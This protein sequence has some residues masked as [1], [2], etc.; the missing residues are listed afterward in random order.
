DGIDALLKPKMAGSLYLQGTDLKY[1]DLMYSPK[2]VADPFPEDDID[3]LSTGSYSRYNWEVF[4]HIPFLIAQRLSENQRFEDA[5]KWFHYIFDPT[6]AAGLP[7]PQGYW[8]LNPFYNN[9]D[10][11]HTI[12]KLLELLDYTGSDEALKTEQKELQVQ[13][14]TWRSNPFEPHA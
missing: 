13:I 4:F 9:T 11:K 10:V 5:M 7:T 14:E 12:E 6:G 8:W 3:F 2:S 1:F